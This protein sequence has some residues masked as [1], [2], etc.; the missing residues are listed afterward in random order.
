MAWDETVKQK[1][2]AIAEVTTIREASEETGVPEGTI[3]RWRHE[4]RANEPN[5]TNRTPKKLEQLQTRAV[6]RAVNEASDY[7]LDRLKG[8]AD[9]L[10]ALAEKAV[11]NLDTAIAPRDEG[12]ETHD[13][14]G[15]A[16]VRA[17]VGV[18]A[19]SVDKA[20][21]LSG[22]PTIR[23]EVTERHVYDITERIVVEHPE[24]VDVIFAERGLAN[25]GG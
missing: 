3:K 19:Q 5:R 11:G 9:D 17:L 8:L 20:Q 13:R 24:L 4:A 15:A 14:D 10:Y 21:L 23:P 18:M 6:E 2:L 12:G 25:R 22:K 16:W 1:A 7:I